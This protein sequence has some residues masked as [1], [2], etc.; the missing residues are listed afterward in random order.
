MEQVTGE[1]RGAAPARPA[2]I[3]AKAPVSVPPR[4]AR[5]DHHG[6]ALNAETY[7]TAR[8]RFP[9]FDIYFVEAEWRKW[10]RG[11]E[12]AEDPDRAFLAFFRKYAGA[13]ALNRF[14]FAPRL[15]SLDNGC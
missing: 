6:S 9:G 13:S 12:P 10:A 11:K 2:N 14:A 1:G 3:S 15:C 4:P 7:A 8:L 5:S